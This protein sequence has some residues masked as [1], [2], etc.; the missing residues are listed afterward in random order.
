MMVAPGNEAKDQAAFK[1]ARDEYTK[2]TDE[3]KRK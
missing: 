2:A 1:K 3:R